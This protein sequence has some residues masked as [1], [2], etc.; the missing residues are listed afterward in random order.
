MDTTFDNL[1]HIIHY[2]CHF[3]VPFIFARLLWKEHWWQT[4]LIML[5]TMAIDADHLLATPIYDANRCSIGFHPLHTGWAA[6]GYVAM[7][8]IP[9]RKWRAASLG[10]LWHLCTDFIDCLL[11]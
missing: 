5:C 10:C 2:G 11:R 7:L 3:G 9:S 1:R 4:G 8:A 6:L